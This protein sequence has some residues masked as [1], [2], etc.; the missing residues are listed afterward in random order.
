M[1]NIYDWGIYSA[2]GGNYDY[3]DKDRNIQ[4]HLMYMLNRSLQM[5]TYTGLPE[6]MPENEV[7]Y[8]LQTHGHG[9]II[10]VD[11]NLYCFAGH[12][13]G[14][15]GVYNKPT[16]ININ[17]IAL[18][19]NK[20][21]KI[22]DVVLMLNDDLAIGLLP[23]FNKYCSMLVESEI[24][25]VM[26][27]INKRVDNIMLVNDDNT[28]ESARLYLK[29]LEEGNLGYIMTNKLYESFKSTGIG[30][31]KTRL[32]ELID[33]NQYIRATMHNE[34]GLKDTMNMKKER[35]ITDELSEN[36]DTI[37]PLIDGMLKNRIQGIEKINKKYGLDISVELNSSWARKNVET[38][39]EPID[40][41]I[42][43]QEEVIDEL[44][45]EIEGE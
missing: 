1:S 44:E 36:Q 37:Y 39:D 20:T 16:E 8:I 42:E 35:L 18:N 34:I 38:I 43:E 7:E 24:T 28:A 5:F 2:V 15:L 21:Y 3:R 6:T 41:P 11:D 9:A 23:L 32:S 4:T 40:E 22:D 45:E 13:G 25:M 30:E 26:T 14:A 33:F 10:E 29:K 19:I 17:N 12:L 27:N 31:V